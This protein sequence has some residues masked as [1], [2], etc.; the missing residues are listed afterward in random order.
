M[1]V[2]LYHYYKKLTLHVYYTVHTLLPDIHKIDKIDMLSM[3]NSYANV[4]HTAPCVSE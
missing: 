1:K 4:Y 2:A 3:Y